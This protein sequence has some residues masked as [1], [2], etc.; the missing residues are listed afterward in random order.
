MAIEEYANVVGCRLSCDSREHAEF[1]VGIDAVKPK[2]LNKPG[3]DRLDD[4]P[5]FAQPAHGFAGLVTF[6]VAS[7]WGKDFGAIF[8]AP[9][10]DP[11]C[12]AES[13]IG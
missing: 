1:T 7:S 12:A 8:Q 9:M 2:G 10:I 5:V 13:T 11:S 6:D 3:E 4:L